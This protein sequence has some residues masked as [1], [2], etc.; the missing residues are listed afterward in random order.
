MSEEIK[1]NISELLEFVNQTKD[2]AVEQA[3]L[4]IKE[5]I[6]F[7]IYESI[8]NLVTVALIGVTFIIC[9]YLVKRNWDYL[10]EKDWGAVIM[11]V[12]MIAIVIYMTVGSILTYE[13]TSNLIKANYAP[14]LL[15]I[16][17]LTGAIK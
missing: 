16:E 4:L 12:G 7:T 15:I 6:Q 5:L 14:R 13:S 2:F 11:P 3:P 17:K 8:F 9:G 1:E 10:Y